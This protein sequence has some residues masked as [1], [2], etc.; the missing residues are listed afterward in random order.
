MTSIIYYYPD[1]A[2]AFIIGNLY[3]RLCL[4]PLSLTVCFGNL[5][6]IA[7]PQKVDTERWKTDGKWLPLQAD[8]VVRPVERA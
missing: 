1:W 4:S 6:Q 3:M 8:R 2:W 5:L 7:A